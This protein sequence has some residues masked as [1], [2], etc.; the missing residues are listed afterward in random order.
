MSTHAE[1]LDVHKA[2]SDFKLKPHKVSVRLRESHDGP[3][4]VTLEELLTPQ[5]YAKLREMMLVP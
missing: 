2:E 3:L 5:I 4:T 1:I